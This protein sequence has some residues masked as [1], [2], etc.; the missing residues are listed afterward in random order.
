MKVLEHSQLHLRISMLLCSYV[1][2][3]D[4]VNIWCCLDRRCIGLRQT[5]LCCGGHIAY[6]S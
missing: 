5:S 4:I 2:A 6:C 1:P 3:V